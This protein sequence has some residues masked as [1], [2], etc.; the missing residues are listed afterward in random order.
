VL[1]ARQALVVVLIDDLD[2]LETDELHAALRAVRLLS[3]LPHVVHVLA[4]DRGQLGRLLFPD[5]ST[6]RLARDYLAKIVH[7]EISIP[8]PTVDAATRILGPVLEPLLDAAGLEE[9]ERFVAR[10]QSRP[11]QLFLEAMP[12]P[13]D[14][15]RAAAATGLIWPRMARDLNLFDLLILQI[16]HIRSPRVFAA[17]HVHPEWFTESSWSR[18]PW[19][20]SES[21]EWKKAGKDFCDKLWASDDPEE[22]NVARLL[23]L[24]F[25]AAS[26]PPERWELA[27]AEARRERRILHPDIFPRYLQ[28]SVPRE[29]ITES[30]AEECGKRVREAPD[31]TRAAV[32]KLELETAASR[33]QAEAWFD[34]WDMF[35]VGLKGSGSALGLEVVRDVGIG[36][37]LAAPALPGGHW[38][39]FSPRRDAIHRILALGEE[40]QD[41]SKLTTF[42]CT[43]IEQA[44]SFTESGYIV[45]L[46]T[47]AEES[48]RAFRRRVLDTH[49]MRATFDEQ[50]RRRFSR[51]TADLFLL[52]EDDLSQVLFRT[53]SPQVLGPIVT[54]AVNGNPKALATLLGHAVKLNLGPDGEPVIN[55]D[56]LASFHPRINFEDI[57]RITRHLAPEYW[58]DPHDRALIRFF[59]SRLPAILGKA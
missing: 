35:L 12:T 10:F 54:G 39:V 4:Y 47:I 53:E 58:N 27:E 46:V 43:L 18:D 16:I 30:G 13:R 57:D 15:R 1:L 45:F 33:G 34:Q 38:G 24:I 32:L 7:V 41:N 23:G 55:V 59:R 28:V 25:P 52:P 3:D 44:P 9:A 49:R 2:R 5:D 21:D 40:I 14:V 48:R 50:V 37:V 31:G 56:E 29:S 6:G 26:R 11:R 42:V 17:L 19:R 22:V 36:V 8:T 20:L 51:S